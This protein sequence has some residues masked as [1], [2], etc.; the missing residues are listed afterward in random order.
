MA[1]LQSLYSISVE[2][3]KDLSGGVYTTDSKYSVREVE[4]KVRQARAFFIQDYFIKSKL[5]TIDPNWLQSYTPTYTPSIQDNAKQYVKFS[6]PAILTLPKNA[7]FFWVGSPTDISR[8]FDIVS[9]IGSASNLQKH[10]YTKLTNDRTSSVVYD[11]GYIYVYGASRN[12]RSIVVKAVW[13]D[14]LDIPLFDE[15]NSEYPVSGHMI[16]LIKDMVKKE[17]GYVPQTPADQVNDGRASM[18]PKHR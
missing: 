16:P 14:P 17:L 9:D 4:E 2:I 7:G 13:E 6:V 8:D 1:S 15:R 11:N 5:R 12:I 18:E 3:I 10:R